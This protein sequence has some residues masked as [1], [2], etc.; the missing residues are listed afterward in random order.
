MAQKITQKSKTK[1]KK[2]KV[3]LKIILICVI[4]FTIFFVITNKN[5]SNNKNNND[6]N[7]LL[8][9]ENITSKLKSSVVIEN[10]QIY[11]SYDDIK[12]FIDSTLYTEEESKNIITTSDKKLAVINIEEQTLEINN[13][14]LD[15]ENI[16]ITKDDII[17]IAISELQ[18]AYDFEINYNNQTNI[19]TIDNLN[20]KSI[21]AYVKKD[22]K[23]KEKPQFF[24]TVIDEIKKG[25]WL[26]YIDEQKPYAKVRTQKGIVGFIKSK[27]LINFE[28][29]RKDFVEEDK[30]FNEEETLITDISK[31]DIT[32]FK[33]R[34]DVIND[35]LKEAVKKEK[36]YIEITGKE[37]EIELLERF[38]L[39]AKPI[40]AECG[41]SLKK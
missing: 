21:K 7:L 24:S 32:S 40:L 6:I 18:N 12:S 28:I 9:N 36:K 33:E 37:D 39:E 30:E 26:Y 23:I 15:V 35:I 22:S 3:R 14:S 11:L 13:S 8:N 31:K 17:Y 41:I 29:E 34:K 19:I 38:K 16:T 10:E 1:R 4:I 5:K 2:N 20:K 27:I 25:D